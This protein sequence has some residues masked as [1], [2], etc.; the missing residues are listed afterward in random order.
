[1]PTLNPRGYELAPIHIDRKRFAS[2]REPD[3]TERITLRQAGMFVS[4]PVEDIDRLIVAILETV[5]EAA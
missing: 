2:S 1:M 5:Q 3:G 4:V